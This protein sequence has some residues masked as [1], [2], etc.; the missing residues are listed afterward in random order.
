MVK[1]LRGEPLMRTPRKK[2]N[3]GNKSRDEQIKRLFVEYEKI[4]KSFQEKL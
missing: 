2:D 4:R 1:I 3:I